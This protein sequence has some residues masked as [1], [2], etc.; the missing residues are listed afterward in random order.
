MKKCDVKGCN[1]KALWFSKTESLCQIHFLEKRGGAKDILENWIKEC[2]SKRKEHLHLV[3]EKQPD[4]RK[5]YQFVKVWCPHCDMWI[6]V[7]HLDLAPE[8]P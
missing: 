8:N 3:R 4:A 5:E 6:W 1:E 2:E 7:I